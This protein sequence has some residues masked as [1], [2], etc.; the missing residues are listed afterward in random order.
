MY[1]CCSNNVLY[2][3]S[4]P[5]TMFIFLLT[6]FDSSSYFYFK[7]DLSLV[8]LIK[9]LHIK[10]HVRMF[11]KGRNTFL[12]RIYFCVYPAFHRGN[13]VKK[14]VSRVGSQEKNIKGE[15]Q[16]GHIEELSREGRRVKPAYSE[17]TYAYHKALPSKNI[18]NLPNTVTPVYN[19]QLGGQSLCDH[20]REMVVIRKACVQWP[21][22]LIVIFA[23]CIKEALFFT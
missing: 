16:V 21:K 12:L 22:L 15:R 14:M 5:L 11:Q 10:N 19:D 1:R 18:T 4:L 13:I 2:S 9:V 17:K 6:P 20:Y 7:S 8:W 3:V 23:P